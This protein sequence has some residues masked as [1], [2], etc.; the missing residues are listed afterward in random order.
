VP[1][2]HIAFVKYF[3]VKLKV[4]SW[5]QCGIQWAG[6]VEHQVVAEGVL[7]WWLFLYFFQDVQY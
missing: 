2:S 4:T 6:E 5:A 3:K 1:L 7:L